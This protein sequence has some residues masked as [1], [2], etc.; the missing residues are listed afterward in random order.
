MAN[1]LFTLKALITGNDAI[2]MEKGKA[3]V[4]HTEKLL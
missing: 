2:S 3:I 4:R 1:G